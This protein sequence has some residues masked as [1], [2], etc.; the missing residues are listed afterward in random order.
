MA[1]AISRITTGATSI[2][3]KE[4]ADISRLSGA[5]LHLNQAHAVCAGGTMATAV[6]TQRHLW[7]SLSSLKECQKAPLLNAPVSTTGLFGEAVETATL[8][9][10]KVEEDRMLLSRHLPLARPSRPDTSRKAARPGASAKRRPG[11][12]VTPGSVSTPASCPPRRISDGVCLGTTVSDTH[13]VSAGTAGSTFLSSPFPDEDC[14]EE[15]I[16]SRVVRQRQHSLKAE[17]GGALKFPSPLATRKAEESGQS[18]LM[19]SLRLHGQS[20]LSEITRPVS[21]VDRVITGSTPIAG[22]PH[23]SMGDSSSAHHTTSSGFSRAESAGGS[24]DVTAGLGFHRPPSLLSEV[25]LFLQ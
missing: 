10:K 7:L 16:D 17:G 5:I 9:F 14:V 15:R 24:S 13:A 20:A 19:H 1:G 25:S 3:A 2:S 12:A 4:L 22:V 8:A 18:G 23:L 21:G 11:M 6:V